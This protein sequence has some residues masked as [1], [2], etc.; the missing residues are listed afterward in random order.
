[1]LVM[2]SYITPAVINP[3]QH[4]F[5]HKLCVLPMERS[6]HITEGVAKHAKTSSVQVKC[7]RWGS[8]IDWPLHW[9]HMYTWPLWVLAAD[10][11]VEWQAAISTILSK[12]PEER[13]EQCLGQCDEGFIISVLMES[14]TSPSQPWSELGSAG[15]SC[16]RCPVVHMC[17]PPKHKATPRLLV[18]GS[19]HSLRQSGEGEKKNFWCQIYNFWKTDQLYSY[20]S[21]TVTVHKCFTLVQH[22]IWMTIYAALQVKETK[23]L[24]EPVAHINPAEPWD[25]REWA[26]SHYFQVQ[27]GRSRCNPN[28]TPAETRT[29][30][31]CCWSWR[32][33]T[34]FKNFCVNLTV[35]SP[36]S[37]TAK[38]EVWPQT[39]LTATLFCRQLDTLRGVGWFAVEPEPTWPQL[40]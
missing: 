10:V 7:V 36:L 34:N 9:P 32:L 30:H 2:E 39:I 35:T 19:G 5:A 26:G 27:A 15:C 13:S 18:P 8:T 11:C 14:L 12:K 22:F 20:R 25:D 40:L 3:L 21:Y 31:E 38:D 17:W 29:E 33:I 1:M 24:D 16:C 4:H 37:T 28:R 6:R 23:R